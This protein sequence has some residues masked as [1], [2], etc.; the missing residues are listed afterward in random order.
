MEAMRVQLSGYI[1]EINTLKQQNAVLTEKTVQLE[2]NNQDLKTNLDSKITENQ[3]LE[4]ARATLVGEKEAL[5]SK[6]AALGKKVDIGSVVKVNAVKV[7]GYKIKDSGK[8]VKKKYAKNIDR[9][10]L[11]FDLLDNGVVEPGEEDFKIRIITPQG[12]T[13]A[14]EEL[15]SGVLK[16]KIS[17]QEIRYTTAASVD[18]QNVANNFCTKWEPNIAFSKGLHGVEIYNKGYLAGKGSFTLK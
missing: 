5:T 16:E 11:C 18:Y 6:T 2:A 13:L 4:A 14:I 7:T 15:G 12:L 10:E 9:L 1:G 17:Q 3:Q 8:A